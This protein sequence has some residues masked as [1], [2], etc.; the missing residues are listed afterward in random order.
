MSIAPAPLKIDQQTLLHHVIQIGLA[1]E[2]ALNA[3]IGRITAFP[4]EL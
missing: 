2:D 3:G 1:G 4:E